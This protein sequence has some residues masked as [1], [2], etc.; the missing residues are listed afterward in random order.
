[1]RKGFLGSMAALLAGAGL[2]LAQPPVP[3]PADAAPLAGPAIFRGAMGP[4]DNAFD[5]GPP[6]PIHENAFLN[7]ECPCGDA[8]ARY[9]ASLEYLLWYVRPGNVPP[10][11]TTSSVTGGTGVLGAPGTS[12][13]AGNTSLLSSAR[14]GARVT[15][16][17]WLEQYLGIPVGV[18]ISG[19]AFGKRSI[20]YYANSDL[21][22]GV[23]VLARPIINALTGTPSTYFVSA[24]GQFG[25]S[26]H[27]NASSAFYGAQLNGIWQPGAYKEYPDILVGV[28]Y[29]NLNEDL[30]VSQQTTLLSGG[31][32]GFPPGAI[33]RSGN[34]LSLMDSFATSN[35][36]YGGQVGTRMQYDLGRFYV[37]GFGTV[38][39]GWTQQVLTVA[40]SSNVITPAG[41]ATTVGGG[42][43]AVAS[44]VGGFNHGEFSVV[45]QVG[46]NLGFWVNKH[47]ALQAGYSFLYWNNVLRPGSQVDPRINP[48]QVPTSVQ[49]G[50]HVGPAL[51]SGS[52]NQQDFWAYGLN[53]GLTFVY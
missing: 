44:N 25:G 29:L 38:A 12:I 10:L 18:E 51:P 8:R 41:A 30:T 31:L 46:L 32:A 6:P 26:F 39:L 37:N 23:P 24:P 52:L 48:T 34:T 21:A 16:G 22:T 13:V 15:I 17:T 49:F 7:D 14:N 20:D 35:T 42:L 27:L 53:A 19:F 3:R 28:R 36:F 11:L 33:L 47:I 1:M 4:Q 45:P 5:E 50:S 43:L 9:W 40:G 2:T